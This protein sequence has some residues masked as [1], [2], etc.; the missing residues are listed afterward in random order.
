MRRALL[1]VPFVIAALV[2]A[3]CAGETEVVERIVEVPVVEEVVK[4]VEVEKIVEVETEK[5]VEV[6][7]ERIV[8][9]E[10]E[11]VVIATPTTPPAGEPV[12]G[13]EL[14]TV[15]QASVASLDSV[16]TEAYVTIAVASHIFETPL[17]WNSRI[18]E[19]PRMAASWRLAATS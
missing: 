3:A 6:E 2:A 8:E 13:G 17:G 14:R 5:I 15:S 16:W 11:R 10:T 9:V 12:F 7:T 18:E 1:V 19:Q 4:E